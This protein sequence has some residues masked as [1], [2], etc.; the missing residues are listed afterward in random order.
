MITFFD[1]AKVFSF[2][3]RG[4][5]SVEIEFSVKGDPKYQSCW[6]GKMPDKN[7]NKKDLYWYGLVPDCSEA[8]DYDSFWAFSSAPIFN[9][10]S[11]KEI[12]NDV[13]ILSIDGCDPEERLP[14]YLDTDS[15]Y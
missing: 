13:G 12:W 8:Y 9:G 6:M 4:K 15:D 3:S 14:T 10:K 11:L 1:I 5:F 7:D 2:D